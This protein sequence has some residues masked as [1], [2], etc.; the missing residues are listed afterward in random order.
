MSTPTI[1]VVICLWNSE[2]YLSRCLE[3]LVHQTFTDFEVLMVDN[4]SKDGTLDGLHEKYP[5]LYLHIHRLSSNIGFAV[6]NNIGAR[7]AHG[8]HVAS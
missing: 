3:A 2:K 5:S 6:A 8:N 1:S 4:G 7:L